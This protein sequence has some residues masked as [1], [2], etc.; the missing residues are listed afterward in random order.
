[1]LKI[2]SFFFC[3]CSQVCHLPRLSDHSSAASD[4]EERMSKGCWEAGRDHWWHDAM[5]DASEGLVTTPILGF[6]SLYALRRLG[7]RKW[8]QK[9]ASDLT[10]GFRR[11][12][13]GV[14]GRR[15]PPLY[16]LHLGVDRKTQG[17]PSHHSRVHAIRGYYLQVFIRLPGKRIFLLLRS[18]TVNN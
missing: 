11:M 1:M 6:F 10:S 16:A 2:D 18:A 5:K 14:D 8:N 3:F 4:Y 13:G 7:R 9:R 17:R 15:G 12:R